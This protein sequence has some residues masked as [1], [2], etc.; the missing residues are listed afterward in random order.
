MKKVTNIND[1]TSEMTDVF[2]EVREKTMPESEAKILANVAGKLIGACKVKLEYN[3]FVGCNE[4]VKF[5]EDGK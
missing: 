4:P 2:N 3:K 1:L 5:L